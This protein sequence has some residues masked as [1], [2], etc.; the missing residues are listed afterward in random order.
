MPKKTPKPGEDD[1]VGPLTERQQGIRRALMLQKK[2]FSTP[3]K[4]KK[5]D[6]EEDV[7]P[8]LMGLPALLRKAAR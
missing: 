7:K 2:Q 8:G 4:K 6:E 1:F 3:V 5:K